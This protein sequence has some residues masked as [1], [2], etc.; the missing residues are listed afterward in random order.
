MIN[1]LVRRKYA[2]PT[3]SSA[4]LVRFLDWDRPLSASSPFER[5]AASLK[6]LSEDPPFN[7]LRTV[8]LERVRD[9]RT[10]RKTRRRVINAAGNCV[11][12]R[13]LPASTAAL[14]EELGTFPAARLDPRVVCASTPCCGYRCLSRQVFTA[15]SQR[16][17]R[18]GPGR[19][20]AGPEHDNTQRSRYVSRESSALNF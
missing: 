19:R 14:R 15:H 5:P 2:T 11:V 9:P 20:R 16:S 17:T 13:L 12:I 7:F 10:L 6:G 18:D 4:G 1:A 8:I 3:N